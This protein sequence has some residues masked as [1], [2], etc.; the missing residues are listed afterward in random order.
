M[1]SPYKFTTY[2]VAQVV[3]ATIL[4]KTGDVH[5]ARRE[6]AHAVAAALEAEGLTLGKRRRV[7]C[8]VCA[9]EARVGPGVAV[10]CGNCGCRAPML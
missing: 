8:P 4:D 5:Q 2:R 7:V 10:L 3:A 1:P 6:I 9:A